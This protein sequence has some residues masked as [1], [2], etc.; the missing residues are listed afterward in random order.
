M[1]TTRWMLAAAVVVVAGSAQALS[2]QSPLRPVPPA[3]APAPGAESPAE[4]KMAIARKKIAREPKHFHG[5]NELAMALT[6]RARETADPAFYTQADDAVK[7][8]L[9]LSPD[10]ME[11]LKV[12]TWSLL[13]QHR[14]AEAHVLATQLNTKVPDDLMVYGM[15]TDANIEL[16]K[17]DEA[18]K[19]AQW[20][21]DLRP[22]NIPALTRAAYLRELF[23]DV[24]GAIELMQS[25]FNRMPYQETEDRAWVL[26]QIGHLELV[27]QKPAAAEQVLQQAL[28]LFPNYHYALGQLADVRTAQKRFKD[29]A[30]LQQQR[31]A[32]AP[33]P[34]NLFEL[35]E[36]QA[37][38]GMTADAAKS[39]AAFELGAKAEMM[40][41]DNANRE[42]IAYLAGAGKK[43]AEAL[44]LA[45]KE[46]AKRGDVYTREAYAWALFKNGKRADAKREIATVLAV[47][48]QHPRV[49]ER[50]ALIQGT[51]VAKTAA[52]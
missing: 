1:Q 38:A 16:G 4:R 50:A 10:N 12:R 21:L 35:A 43:P 42:L 8:S 6:Q 44:A 13:G 17:Y 51:A 40:K 26:T 48:V 7:T 20:M 46:I 33:H 9:A 47:G 15:L 19:S 27:R 25:A 49:L 39:Y 2:A 5:Y 29:A 45:Q 34:E 28:D 37:R 3:A 18:E 22:G 23:G 52:R 30:A 31:Y 11:A 24:E 32:V 36:A 41:D 14:F